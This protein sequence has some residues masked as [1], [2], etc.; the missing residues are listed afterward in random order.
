MNNNDQIRPIDIVKSLPKIVERLP[1]MGRA[2]KLARNKADND[3]LPKFFEQTVARYPGNVAIYFEDRT[4]TY[5]EFNRQAN[6]IAHYLQSQGVG[7]GDVVGL[8][9][10]NRPE[11]LIC[12]V[13][14]AK[15]GAAA[16]LINTA[17]SGK[18]LVHSL[19]MVEAMMCIVGEELV[20]PFLEVQNELTMA[21]NKAYCVAD[22]DVLRDP[23]TVP[24]GFNN[25]FELSK[26]MPNTNLGVTQSIQRSDHFVYIYTSGTTGLPKAAITDH[27]RITTL[28]G[29]INVIKNLN[30]NDIYYLPLPLFHATGLLACWGSVVSAGCAV[31]IRRRFS[32]SEFWDDIN[33]YHATIFGY[34]GEMCRYLLNQPKK[35]TDGQHSLQKMF[36]NGLRPG[37]WKEF[38]QRFK[39]PHI[40]EFYGASEGNT[41][42]MNVLNLDN[43]VGYGK[44]VLV[45]YDK[46]AETVVRDSQGHL[47]KVA[48]GEPGLLIGEITPS[49]PFVGY[50]QK[51]K[52]EAAILRDVFKKGD[53]WFNT[54]DML[55]NIGCSHYQFVD[56]L[57][58]TFRWK[59][60]NV[61]TTQVE[62]IIGCRPDIAGCAVYGVEIPHT[63]GKAGM[64]T[65]TPQ[66]N[67]NIDFNALLSHMQ[68][69]L[70]AYALPVFLRIKTEIDVTGTFKYKKAELKKEG[71][72]PSQTSEPLY[73]LLPGEKQYRP[74][75]ADIKNDID[76]GKYRF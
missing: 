63:N 50:T 36:G 70:P 4:I 17:Q 57:G 46:E 32:A 68:A 11:F 47:I 33:K 30:Q 65:L 28:F 20:E 40:L 67:Q 43:T 1:A 75:T 25:L 73:V 76:A 45:K 60:E 29:R 19:N 6:K 35:P 5:L 18:V 24:A 21:R 3:S 74:L 27:N 55:R 51:D 34:V 61:S 23:G 52:T 8:F 12:L 26:V 69:D 16:A 13:G 64:A 2:I 49:T 37:I 53:A 31:V 39:V 72:D 9:M 59:G 56:R 54:G 58:D 44:A 62:N 41:G 15:T 10:H 66:A 48:K 71:F 7:K 38:K 14:I 42:F 22:R